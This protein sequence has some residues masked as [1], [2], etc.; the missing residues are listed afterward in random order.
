MLGAIVGDIVGSV[1]EF[2]N[3]RALDFP[4]FSPKST[5]TD[6]SVLTFATAKVLLDGLDYAATYQ[7]FARRYPNQGYGGF[8]YHW[9]YMEHPQPYNSFGN[10]SAM[11]VS[12]IGFALESVEETLDE[13]Q[14]S[15]EVTHNHPEGIKGAQAVALAIYLARHAAS[16]SE[17][18]QEI[19]TRFGYDLSRTPEQIRQENRHDETCPGSVPEA[20]IAF[21][22]S[23]DF[24]HAI[25]L[26][27][28]LGGDSDT[29]AC[30]AGGIAQAFYG[31]IP[32][33]IATE[34]L[35][36]L[37]GEFVQILERFN[38]KYLPNNANSV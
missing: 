26:A 33:E 11:R 25:R 20:I 37:P 34:T 21:L 28:S 35:A 31:G 6:D 15:A 27:I 22:E 4:L 38:A 30:M 23:N 9:I 24:E 19:S 16:K 10:G 36:R 12:P 14:S 18:R 29:I 32:Q 3:H 8:F 7:N 5:F 17:I 2:H 1:Y 13:A